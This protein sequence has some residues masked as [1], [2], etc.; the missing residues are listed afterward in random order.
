MPTFYEHVKERYGDK[1]NDILKNLEDV[2]EYVFV[3]EIQGLTAV[4]G[5]FS[6]TT[7]NNTYVFTN[8]I[9]TIYVIDL[10]TACV[11][12]CEEG[13]HKVKSFTWS[14]VSNKILT[15]FDGT[16]TTMRTIL[17]DTPIYYK[18][19]N[20]FDHRLINLAKMTSDT[21]HKRVNTKPIPEELIKVGI[22][23]LP[24]Y[25]VYEF[26]KARNRE[27]FYINKHP[28]LEGKRIFSTRSVKI[29]LIEKY[30]EIVAKLKEV[31]GE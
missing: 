13:Y 23:S 28:K 10:N 6:G 19:N 18:N 15:R 17:C 22:T 8:T 31:E 30:Y 16:S 1:S 12:L 7:R 20:P 27:F 4:A 14:Y 2:Y 11:I 9:N 26:E 21:R 5:R 25:I 29:P 24:K 3:D